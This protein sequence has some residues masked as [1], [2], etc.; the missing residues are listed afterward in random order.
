[1]CLKLLFSDLSKYKKIYTYMHLVLFASYSIDVTQPSCIYASQTTESFFFTGC[2]PN[3][4]ND[5][6][7]VVFRQALHT[8][9]Y[10]RNSFGKVLKHIAKYACMLRKMEKY[11]LSF[12]HYGK[13]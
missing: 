6:A 13:L 12:S 2:T 10:H 11:L 7:E 3:F 4:D 1:M 5:Q 8:L 9:I